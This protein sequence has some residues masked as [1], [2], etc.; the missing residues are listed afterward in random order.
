MACSGS[1]CAD[2]GL[3]CAA[4]RVERMLEANWLAGDELSRLGAWLE[5]RDALAPIVGRFCPVNCAPKLAL[6]EAPLAM[7]CSCW[8]SEATETLE[9]CTAKWLL[10]SIGRACANMRKGPTRAA[11]CKRR[12][13]P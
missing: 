6:T 4:S 11:N 5:V 3:C 1:A 8:N 13:G 7:A 10:P 9:I 2:C 12:A